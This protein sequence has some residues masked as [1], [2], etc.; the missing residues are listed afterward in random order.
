MVREVHRTAYTAEIDG[1]QGK[2]FGFGERIFWM[3]GV[4][5]GTKKNEGGGAENWDFNG[6]K[7]E[8]GE[9]QKD[10]RIER[11]RDRGCVRPIN[12]GKGK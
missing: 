2:R 8:R 11:S 5:R 6:G 1:E 4:M 12:G 9:N 7:R 10:G 3:L